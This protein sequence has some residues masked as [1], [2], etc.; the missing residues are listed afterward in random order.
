M[1]KNSIHP[2]IILDL[3]ALSKIALKHTKGKKHKKLTN[4]QGEIDYVQS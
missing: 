1:T 3:L 4:L 2:K